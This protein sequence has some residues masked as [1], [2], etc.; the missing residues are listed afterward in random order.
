MSQKAKNLVALSRHGIST[1]RGFSL[2]A[3]HYREAVAPFRDM[4]AAALPDSERIAEIFSS[5]PVPERTRAAVEAGLLSL[6]GASAFAVRSS[7]AVVARGRSVTEDSSLTSLAGQFVLFL[8]VPENCLFPAIRRCWGYLLIRRSIGSFRADS[9]YVRD[10]AM[11]VVIQEMVPAVASAVMMTVDPLGGGDVGGI[12]LT[13]GPCEALVSGIASPDEVI[14]SRAGG[15]VLRTS[16]GM[17]ELKIEY[18]VFRP[19]AGNGRRVPV[20]L[21]ERARF[22]V[23]SEVVAS[24]IRVGHR[25]ECIFGQPQDVEL[26]ITPSGD[27]VVTQARAITRLPITMIPFHLPLAA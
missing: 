2:D 27:I 17:K 4:I 8:Q 21:E 13:L 15:G 16:I 7:G 25:I 3:T 19:C 14:F 6:A 12:E 18:E 1:P 26:V 5:V 22:S 11:S 24:L 9:Q 23:S 10:S 20:R